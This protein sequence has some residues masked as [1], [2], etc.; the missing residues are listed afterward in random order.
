MNDP[1]AM[2]GAQRVGDLDA[3]LERTRE[4]RAAAFEERGQR[5]AAHVLH[6]EE[7]LLAGLADVVNRENP[8]MIQ[9]GARL[10]LLLEPPEA[11]GIT[12]ECRG[13]Q[14]DGNRAAEQRVTRE[15]HLAHA[16]GA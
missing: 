12:G 13:E 14:L 16:A 11:I 1:C 2:R 7:R 6:H 4:W 8:R 5:L 10:R 15:L 3:D 9:G